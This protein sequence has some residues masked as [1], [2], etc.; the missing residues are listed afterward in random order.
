MKDLAL[1]AD[2]TAG[3]DQRHSVA[4]QLVAPVHDFSGAFLFA[5]DDGG[6]LSLRG[7]SFGA[8]WSGADFPNLRAIVA[9]EAGVASIENCVFDGVSPT[10]GAV[11]VNGR[12]AALFVSSSVFVGLATTAL[13]VTHGTTIVV[14]D[15]MFADIAAAQ[16]PA[17]RLW[18][19]DA[20]DVAIRQS[21]FARNAALEG[22]GGAV[23]VQSV[24][25]LVVE[26]CTFFG[27]AAVEFLDDALARLEQIFRLVVVESH[28]AYEAVERF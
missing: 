26:D 17:L 11:D 6:S 4:H 18:A 19:M 24:G 2:G 25:A 15:S 10:G 9:V 27:N 22:G 23:N 12:D 7:L 16:G 3:S 21:T 8:A 13:W 28:G 1:F 14:E 20:T 5:V